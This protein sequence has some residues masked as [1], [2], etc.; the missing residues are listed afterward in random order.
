MNIVKFCAG[1]K[2]IHTGFS[3]HFLLQMHLLQADLTKL[4]KA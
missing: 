2:I 1:V 3:M 4:T